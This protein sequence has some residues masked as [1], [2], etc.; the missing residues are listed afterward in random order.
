MDHLKLNFL[1]HNNNF[2]QQNLI[3]ILEKYGKEICDYAK[4]YFTYSIA[5]TDYEGDL[6]DFSLYILP[7]TIEY[8]YKVIGVEIIDINNVNV[9]FYTL[10]TKQVDVSSINLSSGTEFFENKIKSLL[11]SVLFNQSMSFLISQIL[12]KREALNENIMNRIRIGEARVLKLKSGD[13]INA[14]F[15]KIIENTVYF[16]TGKGLSEL[17]R[18]NMSPEQRAIAS[19]LKVK[20]EEE[21]ISL[22]YISSVNVDE[23]LDII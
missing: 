19:E 22:G 9:S 21:L 15:I 20:T 16:Y 11:S 6:R 4:D 5:T 12:L 10:I 7:K 3:A 8:D 1:N 23:I 17:F 14:G 13:D 18:P 2:S